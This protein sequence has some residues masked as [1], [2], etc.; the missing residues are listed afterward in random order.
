MPAIPRPE[1]TPPHHTR[2][3][4]ASAGGGYL[5]DRLSRHGKRWVVTAGGTCLAA[6]FLALSCLAPTPEVSYAALFVGFALSEMWRAPAAVL[7]R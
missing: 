3:L 5:A 7:A 1:L 4:T 6:P 2:S